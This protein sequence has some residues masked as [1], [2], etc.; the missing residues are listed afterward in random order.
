MNYETFR[1][2]F[3]GR[4]IIPTND[5]I[6]RFPE[7]DTHRLTEWQSKGY[8]QKVINRFYA[9][10]NKPLDEYQL[11]F[12]ANR[13]Y[14]PSYISLKSA[15][16]WYNFIPEGVFQQ[17]SITTRKTKDFETSIGDFRYKNVDTKL[18]FGYYPM[19]PERGGFL[20]AEPEKALLDSFYLYPKLK[21]E[22]DLDGLRLNYDEINSL[23]SIEKLKA[24]CE[25]FNNKRVSHLTKILIKELQVW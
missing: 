8:L 19:K 24:Y 4:V 23:C 3:D 7:F 20:I 22:L 2:A 1:Q 15:L 12:I 25:A 5:I 18:F 17:F 21:D 10:S 13:I 9:W 6:K 11:A 14:S 16:R